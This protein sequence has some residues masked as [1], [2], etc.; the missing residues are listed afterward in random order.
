MSRKIPIP[1]LK[2][3]FPDLDR[4]LAYELAR[5]DDSCGGCGSSD[6]VKKF[7]AL[8]DARRAMLRGKTLER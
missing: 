2:H 1:G 8:A 3:E 7:A 6:I 4:Q 5:A